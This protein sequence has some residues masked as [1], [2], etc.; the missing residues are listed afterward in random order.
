MLSYLSAPLVILLLFIS[1]TVFKHNPNKHKIKRIIIQFKGSGTGYSRDERRK[2]LGINDIKEKRKRKKQ[3]RIERKK[4]KEKKKKKRKK[5]RKEN[6]PK[7]IQR[8]EQ[9]VFPNN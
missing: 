6:Q 5:K 9:R 1:N 7:L 4:K 3:R 8:K 2:K